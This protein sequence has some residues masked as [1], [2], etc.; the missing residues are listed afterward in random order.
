MLKFFLLLVFILSI[1]IFV[2]IA[3]PLAVTCRMGGP[4]IKNSTHNVTMN[5]V[6]DVTNITATNA[7]VSVNFIRDN[8]ILAT[9]NITAGTNGK[10]MLSIN[11]TLEIGTY[12]VNVSAEKSSTYAYCTNTTQAS[13]P[14]APA[15][16]NR[17]L[18]VAGVAVY[19][20]T[21]LTVESGTVRLSVQGETAT[22]Q[23][24]FTDG[25]FSSTLTACLMPGKRYMLQI[26]IEDGFGKKSWSY[27]FVSW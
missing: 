21:G 12:A 7:N 3:E 14:Q 18:Q 10:Y 6:G 17:N 20:D 15:C 4:Y 23:S 22:G 25:Q 5:V 8:V 2:K 13:L 16:E 1:V 9:R 27:M 11:T 26:Y 19:P 24:S